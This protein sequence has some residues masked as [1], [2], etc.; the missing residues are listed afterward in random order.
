MQSKKSIKID[1]TLE[2]FLLLDFV[3][4]CDRDVQEG[5]C[6]PLEQAFV[7][8]REQAEKDKVLYAGLFN[9]NQTRGQEGSS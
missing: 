3:R 1:K 8:L 5:R 6:I 2:T 4:R 9:N 7:E